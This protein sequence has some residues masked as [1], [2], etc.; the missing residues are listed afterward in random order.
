M[1][2]AGSPAVFWGSRIAGP[3]TLKIVRHELFV[4]SS[5]YRWL[6]VCIP[7]GMQFAPDITRD[8]VHARSEV[9]RE[10]V[11]TRAALRAGL[12]RMDCV[13]QAAMQ[14]M[15]VRCSSHLP[16]TLMGVTWPRR[17]WLTSQVQGG[18]TCWWRFTNVSSC[19]LC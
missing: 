13:A 8:P 10:C 9:Q 2:G 11:D 5:L 19:Y 17:V 1:C 6:F 3:D 18:P 7:G 15:R 16:R 4:M 12:R 14:L